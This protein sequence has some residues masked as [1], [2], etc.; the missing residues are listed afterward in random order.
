M[1]Q[2]RVELIM[3]L[4]FRRETPVIIHVTLHLHL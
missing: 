4:I 3:K 2:A 1:L